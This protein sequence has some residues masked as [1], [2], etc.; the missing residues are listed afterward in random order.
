MVRPIWRLTILALTAATLA[1]A[2]KIVSAKSGLV[3]YVQGRVSVEGDGLL[4]TGNALRQLKAGETLSTERGRTEVLLNPGAV[5]RLGDMSSLRMDDVTLAAARVS[6]LSGSAVVTI[7]PIPKPN[8]VELHL[9]AGVIVLRHPGVYRFDVPDSRLRVYS[10]RAEVRLAAHL[11]NAAAKPA[12]VKRGR[13]VELD[14]LRVA[15]FDLKDTDALQRW[16]FDRA[17]TPQPRG[18]RAIPPHLGW[19]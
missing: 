15:R 8:R 11:D 1:P 3:Y 12:I 14:D 17:R 6:I 7:N 18:L 16:A 10:G 5:L 4:K 13:F 2:Q 19:R 9:G